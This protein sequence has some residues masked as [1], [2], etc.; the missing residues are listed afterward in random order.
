MTTETTPPPVRT[1]PS[2]ARLYGA[3]AGSTALVLTAFFLVGP[4]APDAGASGETVRR[5][6]E[7]NSAAIGTGVLGYA[8]GALGIILL[9]ASMRRLL[10]HAQGRDGLRVDLATVTGALTATWLMMQGAVS[11]IPLVAADDDGK[12]DHLSDSTLE[13]FEIFNHLGETYSDVVIAVPQSLFML[14]VS[15]VIVTSA[16]LPKW[17]GHLG[18]VIGAAGLLS[19]AQVGFN[20]SPLA[21]LFFVQ[22][23]GFVLWQVCLFVTSLVRFIKARKA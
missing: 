2:V 7:D 15:A 18:L 23:F 6:A 5:W 20:L 3:V 10:V 17:V 19:L 13:T 11:A 1:G 22:L 14:A 21:V 16:A 9:T 8:V 12:L 4:D